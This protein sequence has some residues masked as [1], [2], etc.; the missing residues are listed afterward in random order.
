MDPNLSEEA[1]AAELRR[2]GYVV[3]PPRLVE[4]AEHEYPGFLDIMLGSRDDDEAEEG[5]FHSDTLGR[6]FTVTDSGPFVAQLPE[7]WWQAV[8][9]AEVPVQVVELQRVTLDEN[10]ER[11]YSAMPTWDQLT[12]DFRRERAEAPTQDEASDG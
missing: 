5:S 12:A 10:G 4:R 3:V 9:D 6:G 1:M 8:P 11:Q 7:G 2:R